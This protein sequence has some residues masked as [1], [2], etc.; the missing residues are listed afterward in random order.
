MRILATF[1]LILVATATF[2]LH[3]RDINL[4]QAV[5]NLKKSEEIDNFLLKFDNVYK[6]YFAK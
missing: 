4:V 5:N 6:L 3:I 2:F 1:S